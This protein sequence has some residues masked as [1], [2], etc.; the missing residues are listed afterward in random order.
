MSPV[1]RG[2]VRPRVPA[3]RSVKAV[4]NRPAVLGAALACGLSTTAAAEWSQWADAPRGADNFSS[5]VHHFH[6]PAG[7]SPRGIILLIP[8]PGGEPTGRAF[9]DQGGW[10]ELARRLG[11]ALIVSE[12]GAE[13]GR[14]ISASRRGSGE[15]VRRA[16]RALAD[17]SGVRD[18]DRL[19]MLVYGEAVG[20]QFAASLAQDR[21]DEVIAFASVL[22][23]YWE[24]TVGAGRRTPGI[25][26]SAQDQS[27]DA[28]ERTRA[29]V[30]QARSFGAFWAWMVVPTRAEA[31]AASR[32]LVQ[33][34]LAACVPLR[35]PEGQ[36]AT[37]QP[38]SVGAFKGWLVP[39]AGRDPVRAADTPRGQASAGY[40]FPDEETARAWSRQAQ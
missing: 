24:P 8:A 35:L 28:A 31:P 39:E 23:A 9:A 7:A 33:D 12:F 32:G 38:D 11:F 6:N 34:F 1:L 26:V 19:S 36:P 5:A 3:L 4:F 18:L 22:G 2:R 16:R 10:P 13:G 15:S 14:D 27:D 17:L 37:A 30:R 29:L 40:W 25:F 21:P 20:A